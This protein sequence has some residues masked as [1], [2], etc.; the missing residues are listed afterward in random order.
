MLLEKPVTTQA[1]A[2]ATV[3]AGLEARVG[4]HT[5]PGQSREQNEDRLVVFDLKKRAAVD[6]IS[7]PTVR[8]KLE[9]GPLLLMVCDGM[10]GMAG[11]ETASQ[12]CTFQLPPAIVKHL[13][14]SGAGD[15]EAQQQAMNAAVQETHRSIYERSRSDEK[16][17]GMGCTL[18]A[19]LLERNRMLITQVG[20]S[21]LY[22]GR[23]REIAQLTFDQTIW[24]TL[25]ASGQDPEKTLG[26]GPWKST[27]TQAMGA[28]ANVKPVF[29]EK[30]LQPEDWLVLSSDGLHRV[31][32]L[33]DIAE[34]VWSAGT[35]GEK[36]R[37]M[38]NKTNAGGAPDNVSV[39]VCHVAAAGG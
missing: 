7:E 29:S 16:L 17:R 15:L 2:T 12:M 25:R 20:D 4:A 6:V 35:A 36:A 24:D 31:L 8:M 33:E 9:N 13:G 30:E 18:T 23:E 3:A 27:L 14:K 19:A 37:R 34:I 11:G 38:V 10:G 26:K 28:Q 32:N 21:R 39:I 22:L 1:R 5:D